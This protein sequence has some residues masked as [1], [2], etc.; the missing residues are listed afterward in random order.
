MLSFCCI[1]VS[2]TFCCS[3]EVSNLFSRSCSSVSISLNFSRLLCRM[4]C[5]MRTFFSTRRCFCFSLLR[6]CSLRRATGRVSR[7]KVSISCMN[8]SSRASQ[9]RAVSQIPSTFPHTAYTKP[10]IGKALTSHATMRRSEKSDLC[11]RSW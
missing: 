7:M 9:S 2:L 3:R 10:K 4:L 8:C 5:A 11:M 1:S 6:T